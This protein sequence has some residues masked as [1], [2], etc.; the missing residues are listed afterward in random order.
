[1]WNIY[2]CDLG[3]NKE[4]RILGQSLSCERESALRVRVENNAVNI[5]HYISWQR[6]REAHALRSE[7]I[8]RPLL[9]KH[10]VVCRRLH[11]RMLGSTH[12]KYY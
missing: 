7:Q 12:C 11:V 5:G 1:M 6:V 2:L 8:C 10:G 9:N 3:S 4:F